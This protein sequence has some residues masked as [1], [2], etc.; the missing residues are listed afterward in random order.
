MKYE[1]TEIHRALRS[2]KRANSKPEPGRNVLGQWLATA[3]A[4]RRRRGLQ[5]AISGLT[6]KGVSGNQEAS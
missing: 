3:A 5:K 4:R 2:H 1:N 6:H